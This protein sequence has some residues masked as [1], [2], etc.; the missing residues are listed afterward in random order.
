M[1]ELP[2]GS[3]LA[4]LHGLERAARDARSVARR[5]ERLAAQ[6]ATQPE[7]PA[8]ELLRA[9]LVEAAE[10]LVAGLEERRARERLRLRSLLRA[11][12]DSDSA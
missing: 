12:S 4:G 10:Q 5:V 7:D 2:P 3:G 9:E 1:P 6:L 11:D 8:L